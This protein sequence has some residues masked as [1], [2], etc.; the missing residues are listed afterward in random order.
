MIIIILKRSCERRIKHDTKNRKQNK[1]AQRGRK[2]C[3][4]RKESRKT[5]PTTQTKN[6]RCTRGGGRREGKQEREQMALLSSPRPLL[7]STRDIRG[8]RKRRTL[9]V[10]SPFP[11]FLFL[12]YAFSVEAETCRSHRLT[13]SNNKNSNNSNQESPA[14]LFVHT[15]KEKAKQ[16]YR[17][18]QNRFFQ[19]PAGHTHVACPPSRSLFSSAW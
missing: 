12:V 18:Q 4:K 10:N 2:Q 3:Q 17:K 5:T 9:T 16:A 7:H 11:S 19:N 1:K 6:A 8:E 13:N 15:C 14:H